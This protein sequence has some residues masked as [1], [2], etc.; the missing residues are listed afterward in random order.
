MVPEV[1]LHGTSDKGR[2][3]Q[4]LLGHAV[5]LHHLLVCKQDGPH[6]LPAGKISFQNNGLLKCISDRKFSNVV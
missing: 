5:A 2:M 4:L 6:A 3:Q 1:L